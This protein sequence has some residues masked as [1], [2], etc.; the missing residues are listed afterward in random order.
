MQAV[1][2]RL[3]EWQQFDADSSVGREIRF[4]QFYSASTGSVALQEYSLTDDGMLVTIFSP[5]P[6]QT[7]NNIAYNC[8]IG[9]GV[10]VSALVRLRYF[11]SPLIRL[12][13]LHE[14]ERVSD[15][16]QRCNDFSTLPLESY[17]E[18]YAAALDGDHLEVQIDYE[19]CSDPTGGGSNFTGVTSG[20][21]LQEMFIDN[22]DSIDSIIF[23]SA[24]ALVTNSITGEG[25]AYSSVDLSLN[26]SNVAR[27]VPAYWSVEGDLPINLFGN[28]YFECTLGEGLIVYANR[29]D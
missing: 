12:N 19:R 25:F 15:P 29:Q 18:I 23:T 10:V 28:I 8:S 16:G 6:N 13:S 21:Y 1:G 24:Y 14:L 9:S 11:G 22:P 4:T 7:L 5:G 2:V 3:L 27:V 20:A 26:R 17:F